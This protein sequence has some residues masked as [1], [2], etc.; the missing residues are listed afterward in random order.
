MCTCNSNATQKT[1]RPCTCADVGVQAR[2]AT[3]CTHQLFSIKD[4]IADWQAVEPRH[5]CHVS[6]LL[7]ILIEV[8]S[9]CNLDTQT[10]CELL[11]VL[12][13]VELDNCGLWLQ[14]C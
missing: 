11:V 14:F 6:N 8:E 9:G 12:V 10:L 7:S 5:T 2:S 4:S 13:A 3:C 1:C